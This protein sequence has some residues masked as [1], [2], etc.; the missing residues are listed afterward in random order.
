MWQ[1]CTFSCR[2]TTEL[3]LCSG[4]KQIFLGWVSCPWPTG[5][6][7][8]NCETSQICTVDQK[9]KNKVAWQYQQICSNNLDFRW[10]SV[11]IHLHIYISSALN[12]LVPPD[13]AIPSIGRSADCLLP[14]VYSCKNSWLL[15][16]HH[17]QAWGATG[18]SET[19]AGLQWEIPRLGCGWS[20]S[21]CWET[22]KI[23]RNYCAYTH[24]WV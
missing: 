20:E 22:T 1:E 3:L 21:K 11:N 5:C 12:V 17:H 2:S 9:A 14:R 18:P 19:W 8:S 16:A 23:W 4:R 6:W 13:Q 15:T 7:L 24:D 10:I